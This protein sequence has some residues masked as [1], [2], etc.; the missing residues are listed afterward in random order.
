MDYGGV[1][2]HLISGSTHCT[3]R[4]WPPQNAFFNRPFD[5]KYLWVCDPNKFINVTQVMR[6]DFTLQPQ[7]QSQCQSSAK[8]K[9]GNELHIYGNQVKT[10]EIPLINLFSITLFEPGTSSAPSR[11]IR[12]FKI[13]LL[14]PCTRHLHLPRWPWKSWITGV[15]ATRTSKS[16]VV[17]TIIHFLCLQ[18]QCSSEGSRYVSILMLLYL[19]FPPYRVRSPCLPSLRGGNTWNH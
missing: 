18:L 13:S 4:L 7:V 9:E 11:A 12:K 17:V 6:V 3:K 8:K 10:H 15:W 2:N 1:L 19:F 16:T 5:L 14:T